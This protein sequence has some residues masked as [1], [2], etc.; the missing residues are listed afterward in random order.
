[1]RFRLKPH[2]VTSDIEKAFQH[3]GHNEKDRDVS[4]F[5][6][7]SDPSDTY[8]PLTLYRFKTVLFGATCSPFILNAT[9]LKHLRQSGSET[10]KS[11]ERDLYVDNIL[12]SVT[13]RRRCDVILQ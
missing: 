11:I 2:A 9:L 3:V 5:L 13:K 1:M 6:R 8:S 12:T 7:L 10:A 4:R